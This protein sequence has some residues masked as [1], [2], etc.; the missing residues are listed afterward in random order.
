MCVLYNVITFSVVVPMMFQKCYCVI[1][2]VCEMDREKR[3]KGVRI[4][5]YSNVEKV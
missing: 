1:E 4:E 2:G 5:N 3:N